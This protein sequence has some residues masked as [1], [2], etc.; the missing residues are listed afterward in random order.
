MDRIE[1][2]QKNKL[3]AKENCRL[4]G[5]DKWGLLYNGPIRMGRVGQIS[6]EPQRILKCGNCGVGFLS[7]N[8]IDY[9]SSEYRELV[10]GGN[11]VEHFYQLHDHEQ[12]EKLKVVGTA[13]LR[14]KVV[15]DVGCGAGAFLDLV[16]GYCAETIAIEPAQFYH[17]ALT[18]KGHIGF[19]YCTEVSSEWV[20]KID[21]ATCFDVI[22]HV[23]NPLE[24]LQDIRKVLKPGGKLLVSTPNA[25]DILLELLPQEYRSFFYRLV[26]TWYFNNQSFEHLAKEAGYSDLSVSYVHRYDLSNIMLWLRDK[27]PTGCGK[28][29][30]WPAVDAAFCRMLEAEGRADNIYALFTV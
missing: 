28:L 30:L 7:I 29:K 16:K 21:L 24:F 8:K 12:T 14:G 13:D 9:E 17:D 10:D 18:S 4:C 23:E 20:G 6:Q 3:G 11:T 5:S 25:E 27:R 1:S 22:E 26:H 19:S 15:A 2:T